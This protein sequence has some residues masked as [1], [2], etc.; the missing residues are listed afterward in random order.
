MKRLTDS[1]VSKLLNNI[2][3]FLKFH[4]L[5]V[6]FSLCLTG[7][8]SDIFPARFGI[9]HAELKL[10]FFAIALMLIIVI[11]VIFMALWFAWRYRASANAKYRPEWSHNTLLEVVWWVIPCLIILVLATITWLTSHSLNPYKPLDSDKKP[12]TIEVVS[13][14]WKWL[15]IYPDYGIATIN[16]IEIPTHRPINFKLTSAAPMN[17]FIIPQL[18][19]Q[20]YTMT[21]ME[22]KLHLMAEQSGV[23][24]GFAA[25]YTGTGFA[26][27]HFDVRA[28]SD[29]DFD[30]WVRKIQQESEQLT[31]DVFQQRLLP[32]SVGDSVTYFGKVDS[33][34]F[35]AVLM[36]YM[37]PNHPSGMSM[38]SAHSNDL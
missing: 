31:W 29:A 24:R 21:G 25:N 37:M 33:G 17:S 27:M 13:L 30:A 23:Y 8:Y 15:F 34:L 3:N 16:Y 14:D 32:A 19:G 4:V 6:F 5:F 9:A 12:V 11:P 7:C 26:G 1:R 10:T 28:S 36:Y 18:V 35:D 2:G 38:H 20:I 22:T